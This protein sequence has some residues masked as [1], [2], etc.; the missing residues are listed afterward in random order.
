M[1]VWSMWRR[2][3]DDSGFLPVILNERQRRLTFGESPDEVVAVVTAMATRLPNPTRTIPEVV[4][5]LS[6]NL[7][8]IAAVNL[9]E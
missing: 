8:A 7:P 5:A 6:N 3:L 2:L 4:A 9:P 1:P